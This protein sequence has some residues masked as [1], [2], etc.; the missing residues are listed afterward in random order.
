MK[1]GDVVIAVSNKVSNY[2]LLARIVSI[3]N[4]YYFKY[5][6]IDPNE[7]AHQISLLT[8]YWDELEYT[9]DGRQWDYED[10]EQME[11]MDDDIG[12]AVGLIHQ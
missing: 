10:D 7:L 11:E 3:V 8:K 12:V 1:D 9:Y 2:I 6:H 4:R 5:H